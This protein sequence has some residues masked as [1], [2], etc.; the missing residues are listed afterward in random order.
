MGLGQLVTLRPRLMSNFCCSQILGWDK[1]RI[2]DL[3]G[4][5]VGTFISPM[6]GTSLGNAIVW[7]RVTSSVAL[8]PKQQAFTEPHTLCSWAAPTH[9]QS[10]FVKSRGSAPQSS[11]FPSLHFLLAFFRVAC[12]PWTSFQSRVCFRSCTTRWQV[13]P[14]CLCSL[15][16]FSCP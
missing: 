4:P 5:W 3:L 10:F 8:P 2:Q 9:S 1:D 16:T 6:Q 15:P 12:F 11:A 7:P 13:P 14:S